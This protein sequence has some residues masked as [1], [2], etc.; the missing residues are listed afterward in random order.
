MDSLASALD[1]LIFIAN[2][3]SDQSKNAA[4]QYFELKRLADTLAVHR[5]LYHR[6]EEKSAFEGD[7]SR[8]RNSGIEVEANHSVQGLAK[9]NADRSILGAE[10]DS[11]VL[12]SS[13]QHTDGTDSDEEETCSGDERNDEIDQSFCLSLPVSVVRREYP[14]FS[15][16]GPD[17]YSSSSDPC[18]QVHSPLLFMLSALHFHTFYYT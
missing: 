3:F 7:S 13:L 14:G 16:R 11:D 2:D 18:L 1:E 10:V 4:K 6:K 9:K 5:N 15:Y 12:P 8:H 17:L